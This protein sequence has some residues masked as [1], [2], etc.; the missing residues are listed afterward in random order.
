MNVCV[1]L[2]RTD[3]AIEFIANVDIII[4]HIPH[5]SVPRAKTQVLFP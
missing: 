4:M 2:Y 3:Y 5:I 1:C